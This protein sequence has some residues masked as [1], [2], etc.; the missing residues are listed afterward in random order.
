MNINAKSVVYLREKRALPKEFLHSFRIIPFGK[1]SKGQKSH[2]KL[3]LVIHR[4]LYNN[5]SCVLKMLFL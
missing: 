1:H 5:S 3:S 4:K 2:I